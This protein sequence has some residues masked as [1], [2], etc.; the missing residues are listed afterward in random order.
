VSDAQVIAFSATTGAGR[1][2]LAE[3]IVGLVTSD[4]G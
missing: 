2:E 1:V 4:E 3:A